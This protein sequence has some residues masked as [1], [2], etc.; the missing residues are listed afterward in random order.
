[1]WFRKRA[2]GRYAQHGEPTQASDRNMKT[3]E[4]S[5]ELK[6]RFK[7]EYKKKGTLRERRE[8][9]VKYQH[10][11]RAVDLPLNPFTHLYS[12]EIWF[13]KDAEEELLQPLAHTIPGK[14]SLASSHRA[15]PNPPSAIP[16]PAPTPIVNNGPFS[17]ESKR[18]N[19]YPSSTG[20]S[21]P[22]YRYDQA[23][24]PINVLHVSHGADESDSR[25]NMQSNVEI[26]Q[27]TRDY[28]APRE[29]SPCHLSSSTMP[30]PVK[31]RFPRKELWTTD[32][33][34]SP[35]RN[36]SFQTSSLCSLPPAPFAKPLCSYTYP[37]VQPDPSYHHRSYS[38][39]PL[40]KPLC[41]YRYPPVQPDHSYYRH[42]YTIAAAGTDIPLT[43][44]WGMDAFVDT[45]DFSPAPNTDD[46]VPISSS[47][48]AADIEY[49]PEV[50][51]PPSP[52]YA[53]NYDMRH[54]LPRYDHHHQ[55]YSPAP[56]VVP[57]NTADFEYGAESLE[58]S[59]SP[60]YAEDC[61]MGHHDPHHD[62]HHDHRPSS[63]A[64][65]GVQS[66]YNSRDWELEGSAKTTRI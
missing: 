23:S 40:A 65:A 28:P 44:T 22:T 9:N 14:T 62:P 50:E 10:I 52:T 2:G 46:Q 25:M 20:G 32:T 34:F 53:E 49:D 38:N 8:L 56:V 55:S 64:P 12:L 58:E 42:L 63:P 19:P 26:E 15:S 13:K 3:L 57:N 51:E 21:N 33:H 47:E 45:Q 6:S 5:D 11:V 37:P 24:A 31:T 18:N 27:P 7:I 54:H 29:D 59:P 39:A 30:V 66:S 16:P 60:T 4:I 41:S 36:R 43:V 35:I 61:Y 1:M 17:E 48:N